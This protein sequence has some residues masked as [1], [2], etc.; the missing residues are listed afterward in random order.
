MHVL[1][2]SPALS[3]H[4][5]RVKEIDGRPFPALSCEGHQYVL[6]GEMYMTGVIIIAGVFFLSGYDCRVMCI[7]SV[8]L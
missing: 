7:D 4:C 2:A 3:G 6:L 5:W 1:G 8:Y